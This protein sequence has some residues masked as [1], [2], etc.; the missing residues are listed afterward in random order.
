MNRLLSACIFL[1]LLTAC[2][3]EEISDE[4]RSQVI[5]GQPVNVSLRLEK[6][7]LTR[8]GLTPSQETAINTIF[9]M[10][11][12]K[13][14]AKVSQEF[15][16]SNI[17]ANLQNIATRSGNNMS[18]YVI[19]NLSPHNTK[20]ALVSKAFDNV[21]SIAGLNQ[22]NIYNL[23]ID[24]NANLDLVAYGMLT[25][26]SIDPNTT[27]TFVV[28]LNYVA[29]R[30]TLYVTNA[31]SIPTDSYDVTDWTVL[32]YPT[33]TYLIGQST[34][35]V[36]PGVSTDY[37]NSVTSKTWVDTTITFPGASSPVA[38]KYAF[39]YIYENRRGGRTGG[40][41]G[42]DPIDKAKYAPANASAIQ[43]RGYYKALATST[44][45]GTTTTI[46]LGANSYND[47]NVLR[48]HDYSCFA[49]IKGINNIVTDSRVTGS[50][51]GFQV[52]LF[53]PT[54]DNH[55]DRRPLQIYCWPDSFTVQIYESDGVTPAPT[56]FWLKAS[57][58]DINKAVLFGG[59]YKR[60]TYTP[61]TDMLYTLNLDYN[62]NSTSS[63]TSELVYLYADENLTTSPRTAVIKVTSS[64]NES[65]TKTI[66]QKG[67]QSMGTIGLRSFNT[68]GTV[69]SADDYML[70]VENYEESTYNLTPGATAGTE[71]TAYMQWGYNLTQTQ[72]TATATL[73]YYRRNGLNNTLLT[74]YGNT[75]G[76]LSSVM[77][78]GFGR[79]STNSGSSPSVSISEQYIDP[80]FNTNMARYCFE[81]NRDLDGDG[82]I[83]NPN[84]LGTNEINWY[85]PAADEILLIN[86]GYYAL[87]L[88]PIQYPYLSSTEFYTSPTNSI[89]FINYGNGNINVSNKYSALPVRCVRRLPQ[90]Q[91]QAVKN[92]PYVE[93]GS[94]IIN[95]SQFNSG[96][97]QQTPVGYP[98]PIHLN[99]DAL[100]KTVSP[101]FQVAQSDCRV[102]GATGSTLMTWL[103]A[104]S[105]TTASTS[106][107]AT[108]VI[109]SPATGCH[110][111][112]EGAY[113]PG[114]WR[115][116]NMRE[117]EVIFLLRAE[118]A[119]P[120]NAFQYWT[121]TASPTAIYAYF[122]N[123]PNYTNGVDTKTAGYY[124]RCVHDL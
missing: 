85:L 39:M 58:L 68:N 123:K 26:Q 106:S 23:A 17:T 63:M 5:E 47:Y 61:A 56:G 113:G 97:L 54:L 75:T 34:D 46:H 50:N 79:I 6:A 115:V 73:E 24:L 108:G 101:R 72:L 71:A 18:I 37:A 19:T 109:A 27:Q 103:Q 14:G 41:T 86:I 104:C 94:N 87:A 114:T 90:P 21:S 40:N 49:T 57:T 1:S 28:P 35:A 53:Q 82:K 91:P 100:N 62:G 120:L 93:T 116:P 16:T 121:A 20:L 52:N 95:N 98:T 70:L 29:A 81:K 31:L 80:V 99:T 76:N 10:V 33:R 45:T 83:T 110:A 2:I 78:P 48:G 12:D 36:T 43:F 117:L 51:S 15:F 38:A 42:T 119:Y 64:G 89:T 69:N 96:S 3:S 32:N 105:W 107:N 77:L 4:S 9:V 55:S 30:V 25:G 65:I 111:Y 122:L 74:V 84:T 66:T 118:L 8:S 60:P 124:V 102:S 22:F 88:P 92:S 11:F 112:S 67:Y 59:T 7:A 13:T 44:V